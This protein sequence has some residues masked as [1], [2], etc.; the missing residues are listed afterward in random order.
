[1]ELLHV[2]VVR[3]KTAAPGAT[4]WITEYFMLRIVG[5]SVAS[6]AAMRNTASTF[7]AAQ[8]K[9]RRLFGGWRGPRHTVLYPNSYW[10]WD[11]NI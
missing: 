8:L 9:K 11:Q 2:L 1:M 3:A 10:T 5:C 4:S 7:V 6:D